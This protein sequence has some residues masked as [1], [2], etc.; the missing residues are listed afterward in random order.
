MAA[1]HEV[2]VG[3]MDQKLNAIIDEHENIRKAELQKLLIKFQNI[4]NQLRINQ[5]LEVSKLE[6]V[7]KIKNF[8]STIVGKN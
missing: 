1:K 8:A 7:L 3:I 4:N 6:N 2:E 5:R